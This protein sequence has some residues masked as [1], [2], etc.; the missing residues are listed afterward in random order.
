MP[1]PRQPAALRYDPWQ[2]LAANWPEIEVVVEPMRGQLL[3]ILRYPVV[4]LRA[5]TSAA[6]RRCTLAHELVHLE[7]G[8]RDCGP[9]AAR[10]ELLV[11]R[12]VARRLVSTAALLDGVR[13]VGAQGR[14]PA[15][16]RALDVDSETA[17][18]RLELLT[19]AER[20][21]LRALSAGDLWCVA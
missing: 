13:D 7:R 16:A 10:E 20:A 21:V 9:W 12:E 14:I 15:L 6:Q 2:D 11:Q 5:G 3:G 19:P 4:A 18:L 8:V 17:R 1:P